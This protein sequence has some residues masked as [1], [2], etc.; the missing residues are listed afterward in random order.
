[1]TVA[2]KVT[3]RRATLLS[4]QEFFPLDQWARQLTEAFGETPYLV[5]S[6]A[7]GSKDTYRDVDVRMLCPKGA[8][9]LTRTETR[10][11]TVNLA[12]TA[13]GRNVTN[14]PIDFQFQSANEF[15]TYD[16]EYRSALGISAR[17]RLAREA[18]A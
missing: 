2:G 12:V 3:K 13:W 4:P 7:N 18:K 8:S 9:W 15:H 6:S 5:G 17:A 16:D 10:R 1:M 14:L 11:L